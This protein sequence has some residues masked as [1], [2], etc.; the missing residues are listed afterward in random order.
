[1]RWRRRKRVIDLRERLAPYEDAHYSTDWRWTE[2]E[3]ERFADLV[4]I[5][6]QRDRTDK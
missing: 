1:M 5:R 4:T 2:Q 6:L 3:A